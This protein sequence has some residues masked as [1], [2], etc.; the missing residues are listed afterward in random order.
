MKEKESSGCLGVFL[1]IIYIVVLIALLC[2]GSGFIEAV[3]WPIML[4]LGGIFLIVVYTCNNG[5]L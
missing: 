2:E 1:F 3:L 5:K 4:V